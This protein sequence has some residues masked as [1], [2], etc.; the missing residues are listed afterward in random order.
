MYV[1]ITF[2]KYEARITFT[3]M[4]MTNFAVGAHK[5]GVLD[6]VAMGDRG[7]LL[8]TRRRDLLQQTPRGSSPAT[9]SSCRSLALQLHTV[10]LT[11]FFNW[12]EKQ[13]CWCTA[14]VM[15]FFFFFYSLEYSPPRHRI[16]VDILVTH[17]DVLWALYRLPISIYMAHD[18]PLKIQDK[19]SFSSTESFKK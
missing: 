2:K 6:G 18:A 9:A 10:F 8:R 1:N 14:F 16:S 17:S 4:P 19:M 13:F 12:K 11:I 15:M 3:S 5:E 7:P